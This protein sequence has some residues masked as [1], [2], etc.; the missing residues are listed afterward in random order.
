M[1]YFKSIRR[2]SSTGR[3]TSMEAG[4]GLEFFINQAKGDS[5][6]SSDQSRVGKAGRLPEWVKTSIPKGEKYEELKSMLRELKLATVCEEA[7][8]PNIGECWNGGEE[9]TATATIMVS[10][11]FCSS[12]N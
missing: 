6:V 8:C 7:R 2:L 3:S 10:T 1:N 9:K 11:V 12:Y 4:P 5:M